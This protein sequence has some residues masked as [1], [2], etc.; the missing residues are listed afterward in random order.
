MGWGVFIVRTV[1][2]FVPI[3]IGIADFVDVIS[4]IIVRRGVT[5]SPSK[6]GAGRV[7]CLNR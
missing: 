2:S 6:G 3:A 4:L 7:Y 5:L 1:D